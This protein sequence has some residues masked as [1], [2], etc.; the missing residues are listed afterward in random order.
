MSDLSD[1]LQA[2][3]F[4]DNQSGTL[5]TGSPYLVLSAVDALR[6]TDNALE[7]VPTLNL[8]LG[9]RVDVYF[10]NTPQSFYLRSGS[11]SVLQP[12]S[13]LAPLDYN[14]TTNNKH[15]LEGQADFQSLQNKPTTHFPYSNGEAWDELENFDHAD[16]T[17]A[18][19]GTIAMKPGP[20]TLTVR[21]GNATA[22]GRLLI[23]GHVGQLISGSSAL[24]NAV[25]VTGA[26]TTQ[27]VAAGKAFVSLLHFDATTVDEGNTTT[28]IM[29]GFQRSA[30]ASAYQQVQIGFRLGVNSG[31]AG[32][33]SVLDNGTNTLL[34]RR[35]LKANDVLGFKAEP[36]SGGWILYA[37]GGM[38]EQFG[39]YAGSN[40]WFPCY[41]S[42]TVLSG[43]IYP[44][45]V[46][47]YGTTTRILS[48][49]KQTVSTSNSANTC[50][51]LDFSLQGVDSDQV[52]HITSILR[53]PDGSLW[54][55]WQKGSSDTASNV[56]LLATYI[57]VN[58]TVSTPVTFG[59]S[60]SGN[61][62]N[63]GSVNLVN[64]QIW[65][66]YQRS[67]DAWVANSVLHYKVLTQSD[68][69]VSASA[70]HN[71]TGFTTG[72]YNNANHLL[73]LG[74]GR[75]IVPFY[76]SDS[77]FS[78]VLVSDDNGSTW[79]E[80]TNVD[81]GNE[82]QVVIEPDGTIAMYARPA[83]GSFL[84]R[85]VSTDGLTFEEFV[86][87]LI[88]CPETRFSASTNPDGTVL[89]VG[90]ENY[91]TITTS[92]RPSVTAY[93]VGN[94]GTILK[95]VPL[96][97]YAPTPYNLQRLNYP[98]GFIDGNQITYVWAHSDA[99]G[100]LFLVNRSLDD[101][102]S[103]RNLATEL[104]G[105]ALSGA[106]AQNGFNNNILRFTALLPGT[107]TLPT[108]GR[109]NSGLNYL[110]DGSVECYV[111]G[112]KVWHANA[113]GN[114]FVDTAGQSF[115]APT[116][117]FFLFNARGGFKSTADGVLQIVKFAGTVMGTAGY[118]V[119]VPASAAA[120]GVAG[121]YAYDASFFYICTATDTWKRV[122]IAA[123]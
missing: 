73:T 2:H 89:L 117:G 44:I 116:D 88:P 46:S 56:L 98:D 29:V 121:S 109:G 67:S 74:S 69:V 112:V 33:I 123:W 16:Q 71:F 31:H 48:F 13:Q 54:V 94:G 53:N 81:G 60:S 119:A 34:F 5:V 20:G 61:R 86:E 6:D 21:D 25:A 11:A 23:L 37:Q 80:G 85:A 72:Y 75:I 49:G 14:L 50:K 107:A 26:T 96:A 104:L 19:A 105:R 77:A 51:L 38:F 110:T 47:R 59:S 113:T 43:N 118:W 103:A 120:T 114:L 30:D 1:Y 83:S 66:V 64:G 22:V 90:N 8:P 92:N 95:K 63:N 24:V 79:T 40:N 93:V 42:A 45:V 91:T 4:G 106:F 122:A 84:L 108:L 10:N 68:G 41:R 39:C 32:D 87:T 101:L 7:T 35:A 28:D 57:D 65:A 3:P 70:E 111:A 15:W 9:T 58:G 78:G 17:I 62:F 12:L 82:A 52:M 115:V 18:V 27:A 99:V 97:V 76:T 55:T 102:V 100:A 36:S